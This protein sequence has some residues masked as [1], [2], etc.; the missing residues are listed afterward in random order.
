MDRVVEPVKKWWGEPGCCLGLNRGYIG[1]TGGDV[2]AFLFLFADNLSSLIAIV[3]EMVFIPKIVFQFKPDSVPIG[4]GQ[5]S[6]L[7][8]KDY[9]DAWNHTV[10][11][12]A[13][14]GIG[15][16]LVFGNLWYSW[17]ACKLAKQEERDD[18]TALPYGINTPAGFLT[19][20][21][22][23]LPILFDNDPSKNEISPEEFAKRSFYG[24]C[25]ANFIGG[26]FECCGLV[27]GDF[28]RK[29][30]PRAALFAPVCGVGF[31]WLGLNPLI[32][33]M[34][35]PI[36]GMLPLFVIFVAFFANN[37]KGWYPQNVPVA[38]LVMLFG[39]VLWWCGLARHDTEKRELNDIGKMQTIVNDARDNY[40]G[41]NE[42]V[43]F[44]VLGGFQYMK[45][46]AVA[47]QFPIALASFIETIENVEMA[48][49]CGD[50][51]NVKEA[52]LADGL[53]TI[54]GALFG[55]PL[56]TT[57]YIG[58]KRHK[59]AGAKMAYS[60]MNG[61]TYF[62]L[63][64]A[65]IIPVL[66]YCID[67]VTIGCVLIAVGLMIA[68]LALEHSASR[69]YP[70]L[71]I[72]IMFLIADMLYFDHFDATVRVATRSIGRMK[73]V[74]N[75]APGGGILCSLI[76]PAILCDLVDGRFFRG[77]IFCFIAAVLSFFGLMHGAN[78]HQ[79]DGMMIPV[80]GADESDY[81]TTDLGEFIFPSLPTTAKYE[82]FQT[83]ELKALGIGD[84]SSYDWSYKV[85]DLGFEDPYR[86]PPW[87]Q[88]ASL[89]NAY[90]LPCP[91]PTKQHH[92]YNEGW[93]FAFIYLIGAVIM[94]VHGAVATKLNFEPILDN[95]VAARPE[96]EKD[97]PNKDIDEKEI[98]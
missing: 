13:C 34:R 10:F 91:E 95:G 52:M 85:D 75:M 26:I 17:M 24:A 60:L 8:V 80:M 22:V 45:T 20:F 77:S 94:A 1:I 67:P 87:M 14:P 12:K 97:P 53:G 5:Y 32:D 78:Y 68:Q 56:P 82:S 79:P 59:V 40:L 50:S 44:V 2:N 21:M 25:C 51:Y 36:I 43:A 61:L 70:C 28:L 63:F 66:F 49:L 29:N 9:Q 86:C 72:G 15:F 31:V 83:K 39:T 58:H 6:S 11:R 57:V 71:M 19:V 27:C 18:V 3:G 62:I 93:R 37:G 98:I 33:V 92:A 84:I 69:H 35:E 48:A 55:S 74:M 96:D 16:A 65:G 4:T 38:L 73:G 41:K 46:N 7:T 54:F 89:S 81:Y 30:I 42:M 47:V 23:M 88:N 64:M 76:V 90:N